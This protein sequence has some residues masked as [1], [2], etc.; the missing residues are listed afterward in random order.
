MKA[1][2]LPSALALLLAAG[3]AAPALPQPGGPP[4]GLARCQ[5]AGTGGSAR[6]GCQRDWTVLLYMAAD[7]DLQEHACRQ[8][9]ALERA[10][11]LPAASS[12]NADIL[13]QVDVAEPPGLRRIHVLP[14][15]GAAQEGAEAAPCR[16][17]ALRSPV[18]G[19]LEEDRGPPAQGLRGFLDWGIRG[20]PAR[21]YMV[22]VWGH[23]FG[24]RPRATASG[25]PLPHDRDL[26][27]GGIA[28]DE[29]PGSVLD[30]PSLGQALAGASRDLLG[31]RPLD[32]YAADACLMQSVEV[33]GELSGAAR[34]LIG[35]EQIADYA[36]LPYEAFLPRLN[37]TGERLSAPRCAEDDSACAAAHVL[38]GLAGAALQQGARPGVG[39]GAAETHTFSALD[40]AAVRD[41]LLPALRALG[42]AL[43]APSRRGWLADLL[44]LPSGAGWSALLRTPGF[45]GGTRDI[46][47]FAERLH[48]E[49]E[50]Q[51]DRATPASRRALAAVAALRAA[52]DQT[53]VAASHGKGYDAQ[54]HAGMAGVSLWLPVDPAD[55]HGRI[56]FFAASRLYIYRP[57]PM[58][59]IEKA[60]GARGFRG[61]LDLLFPAP[62]S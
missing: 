30:I 20:Y 34:Y 60:G 22:I 31:G 29:H 41:R 7:N 46:G 59:I 9:R 40:G 61:W 50:R 36:G 2:L 24:W 26:R 48:G 43:A 38:P 5:E 23:G 37:G 55:Y 45:Y 39:P 11:P 13:V 56:D 58:T 21:R 16:I 15:P 53:V 44:G 3:C 32:L 14:S 27:R 4:S 52:L 28:L 1:A 6:A 47:V 25:T 10:R 18:L 33:A 57:M 8:L 51:E 17:T 42:E 54:T 62:G 49:I 35:S 19:L 12:V